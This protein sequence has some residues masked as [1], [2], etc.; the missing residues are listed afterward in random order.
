MHGV[1]HKLALRRVDRVAQAVRDREGVRIGRG[2]GVSEEDRDLDRAP[3][4][5]LPLL[6]EVDHRRH[7]PDAVDVHRRLAGSEEGDRGRIFGVAG[8]Q[9]L[10]THFCI[11]A[12]AVA[13]L[14]RLSPSRNL[15]SVGKRRPAD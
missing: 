6:G 10:F 3:V 7:L 12:I 2:R 11:S 14:A 4:K 13:A 9:P 8:A 15:P 5:Q 1:K